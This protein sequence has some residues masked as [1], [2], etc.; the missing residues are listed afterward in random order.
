MTQTLSQPIAENRVILYPITW[1]NYK[2]LLTELGENYHQILAY[3]DRYLEI[4]S[5]LA[6][7]ENNNRF[8]ESLLGVVVDEL[9][10]N[11]KILG[12][13]TFR[14]D[15]LEK[16]FEPDSCYY[17]QN[18]TRVRN[19][20]KIDSNTTPPPDLVLEIDLTS[21][22]LNKFPIYAA[23]AVPEIWR[24]KGGRLEVFILAEGQYQRRANSLIFPWL[25]LGVIPQLIHRSLA[26][27][28]TATLKGF[29]QYLREQKALGNVPLPSN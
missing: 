24:Y 7:H 2:T 22:S 16:G 4:M 18:E 25:D 20:K 19:S 17:I 9:G 15:D 29:R 1:K 11:I 28:E 21:G 27:G 8:I 5:P 10:I 23:F 26:E 6:G 14:R 3:N 12:S 13:L